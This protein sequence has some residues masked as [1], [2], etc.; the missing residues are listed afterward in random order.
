MEFNSSDEGTSFDEGTPPTKAVVVTEQE[1]VQQPQVGVNEDN[2][3]TLRV[4]DQTGEEMFFR[5]KQ[6]THMKKIFEAFANRR[7]VDILSLRFML[8]GKRITAEDTPKLLELEEDDQIDV[9][10]EQVGG[11]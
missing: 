2:A 4:R 5:V 9:V 10:L 6:T 11:Y 3:L 1:G 7:G 8:E